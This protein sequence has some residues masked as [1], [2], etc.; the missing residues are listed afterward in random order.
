MGTAYAYFNAFSDG[1]IVGEFN[2]I[3]R[4]RMPDKGHYDLNPGRW[5]A[6]LDDGLIRFCA[7]P[8]LARTWLLKIFV[9]YSL[10]SE[11]P[12]NTVAFPLISWMVVGRD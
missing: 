3:P 4:Q 9:A 2:E 8:V 11:W 5:L 1:Y 10:P 7:V 12:V 6:G